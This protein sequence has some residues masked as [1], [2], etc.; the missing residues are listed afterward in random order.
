MVDGSPTQTAFAEI[1][2]P[3]ALDLRAAHPLALALLAARGGPLKLDGS[4]VES[5]GAQCMQVIVSA[6]Q[7]WER[8]AVPLTL[9]NPTEDLLDAFAVAGLSIDTIVESE[10]GR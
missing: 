8:D 9:T 5:I 7:T 10:P 6:R 4:K 1:S 2:L 3:E